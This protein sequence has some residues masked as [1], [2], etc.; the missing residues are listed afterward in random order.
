MSS[1]SSARGIEILVRVLEG[2]PYSVVAK[3][4]GMGRSA[5]EKRVKAVE[6]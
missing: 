4:F 5:V 2:H 6:R 3:E 1:N